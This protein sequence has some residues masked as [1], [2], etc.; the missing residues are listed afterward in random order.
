[1]RKEKRIN[2]MKKDDRIKNSEMNSVQVKGRRTEK[3]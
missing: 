1:M 2:H 3:D